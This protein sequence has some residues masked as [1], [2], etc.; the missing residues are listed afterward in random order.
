MNESVLLFDKITE[1]QAKELEKMLS[2]ELKKQAKGGYVATFENCAR[3]EVLWQKERLE[4]WCANRSIYCHVP[5]SA[6]RGTVT[7]Y[8]TGLN[9][10]WSAFELCEALEKEGNDMQE[11]VDIYIFKRGGRSQ[12][13][14]K[15]MMKA[16]KEIQEWIQRGRT[17]VYGADLGVSAYQDSRKC[18]NCNRYGHDK[19]DCKE[20]SAK[21]FKCG[22]DH[23][24]RDCKVE[25]EEL[26]KKCGYCHG[27][28]HE[29][30]Q[31]GCEM[32]GNDMKEEKERRMEKQQ[33]DRKV[34]KKSIWAKKADRNAKSNGKEEEEK[35]M[36]EMNAKLLK[37]IEGMSEKLDE[38][39]KNNNENMETLRKENNEMEMRLKKTN[40]EMEKRLSKDIKD[41]AGHVEKKTRE[42]EVKMKEMK[43]VRSKEENKLRK[44]PD[45]ETPTTP[46]Q[47]RMSSKPKLDPRA[48]EKLQKQAKATELAIQQG[49]H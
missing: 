4:V 23:L 48:I 15:V 43:A 6:K 34:E 29:L 21:C 27:E 42:L 7:M 18:H 13:R 37:M 49:G 5:D 47:M 14:A 41:L 3:A 16:S 40:N 30:G 46:S 2:K 8:M 35:S 26:A 1:V 28:A 17:K 31:R 25:K 38:M 33:E 11:V 10:K 36:G 12:E 32:K 39:R 44:K 19:K 9:P 22:E 45:T 24:A 20:G